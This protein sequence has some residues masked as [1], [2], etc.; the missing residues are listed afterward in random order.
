MPFAVE[1]NMT[2]V[3]FCVLIYSAWLSKM[4]LILMGVVFACFISICMY[5]ISSGNLV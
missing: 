1:T 2:L 5:N 4:M 3:L